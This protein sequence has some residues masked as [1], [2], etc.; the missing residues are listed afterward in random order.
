MSEAEGPTMSLKYKVSLFVS[1]LFVVSGLASFAVNQWVIMPSFLEL[2]HQQAERNTGRSVEAIHRDLA[3]LSTNVTAWAQWDESKLFVEGKNDAF[4]ERELSAD[5]FSS[6][7]VDFMGFYRTNGEQ[8]IHRK[9]EAADPKH[10]GFGVLERPALPADHPLLSHADIL[11]DTKGLLGTPTGPMLVASR[12]IVS[13]SGAGPAAGVL[14]F[15]RLLD[16]QTRLRIAAQYK[17]DLEIVPMTAASP[18]GS[19]KGP[20]AGSAAGEPQGVT[21]VRIDASGDMLVGET[22]IAD[23]HGEPIVTLHVRTPRDISARGK[24]ASRFALATL[25]GVA[26]AVLAT[27]LMLL[28]YTVLSPIAKLTAHA[29]DVGRNDALHKRLAM[30]RRDE[31]GVLAA[32]FDH[33]TNSL[34]E[35][36]QRLIDQSFVFGKAEMASG[37]LHNLGNAITPLM[38]RLNTLSD[39]IKNAPSEDLERAVA[40]LQSAPGSPQ[41]RADLER[42]VQLAGAEL[43]S[44]LRE[45]SEH[46]RGGIVQVEHIQQ[47]LGEQERYSHAGSMTENVEIEPI[48]RRVA[49]GLSPELL[50]VVQIEIHPSV[51]A[52]GPVR[53]MR[54]EIQQIIGNLVLNA[55]ESIKSHVISNG[56][57]LVQARREEEGGVALAHVAFEDNGAGI[58][59][60]ALAEMFH[61][62]FSTKKRGSGIGLHWSANKVSAMGGRLFAESAGAG[63]GATLHLMLPL[64]KGAPNGASPPEAG[65]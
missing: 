60:E 17:L 40:E 29:V 35:A 11:S 30:D 18:P 54:V 21:D 5:A 33:M 9:L 28:N 49:A 36:R 15:G 37:M 44:L 47:I 45:A 42:F 65:A 23:L 53:G 34:A 26:F 7:E 59:P 32:E 6:A 12:P 16:D 2:E 48:V 63:Q 55:A 51:Q 20:A 31:L 39:R 38:V 13:S 25:G 14:V 58:T 41:R 46:V 3:V 50:S 62:R 57:I 8:V 19:S 43:V 61:R 1:A 52:L 27:L 64:A 22:T 56:R 24:E 4:V 10:L